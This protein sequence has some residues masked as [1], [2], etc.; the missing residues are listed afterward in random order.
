MKTSPKFLLNIYRGIAEAVGA[1]CAPQKPGFDPRTV[2]MGSVV[3][4]VALGRITLR[5][6]RFSRQLLLQQCST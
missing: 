1:S 6:L 2:H 5:V 4:E 3:A